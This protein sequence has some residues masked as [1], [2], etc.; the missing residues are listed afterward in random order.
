MSKQFRSA[1]SANTGKRNPLPGPILCF[2]SVAPSVW[3]SRSC[4]AVS[5]WLPAF[6]ETRNLLHPSTRLAEPEQ[7][8]PRLFL[9]VG[10]KLSEQQ[11]QPY[12]AKFGAITDL[13]LPK[14]VNGCNKGYG[15]L[16]YATKRAQLSVA[17]Q[18]RHIIDGRVF[19]VRKM[20]TPCS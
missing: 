9:N 12:F 6:A 2:F 10:Y 1:Y 17:Q 3:P 14:H 15:F 18:P 8:M 20:G 5:S 4:I 13:Y 16:T 11:L 19:Q 7:S